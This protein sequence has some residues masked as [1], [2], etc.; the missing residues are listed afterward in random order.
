MS[1]YAI[2]LMIIGIL[3]AIRVIIFVVVQ[4]ISDVD[5]KRQITGKRPMR[6]FK[7][8]ERADESVNQSL[9]MDKASRDIL[10]KNEI[11]H[12]L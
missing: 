6:E 5:Y 11:S 12:H 4:I 7:G 8:E 2:I 3:V 9:E 1:I 10:T